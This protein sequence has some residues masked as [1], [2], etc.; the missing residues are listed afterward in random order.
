MME[1]I[2]LEKDLLIQYKTDLES[3]PLWESIKNLE[4]SDKSSELYYMKLTFLNIEK[5]FKILEQGFPITTQIDD[6]RFDIENFRYND[7]CDK[8]ILDAPIMYLIELF[9]QFRFYNY[10]QE[11]HS[12]IKSNVNWIKK[13]R[14]FEI[15]NKIRNGTIYSEIAEELDCHVSTISKINSKVQSSINNLKGRFFEIKFKRY[16]NSLDLIGCK[17]VRDGRPGKPDIYIVNNVKKEMWV[18]SLKNLE[19]NKNSFTIT[20]DKLMPEYNVARNMSKKFKIN[21]Y[22]VLFDSLTE[23]MFVEELDYLNPS[24]VIV[25][26]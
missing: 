9:K 15:Y 1:N 18:L 12:F 17:I 7:E 19:L 5:C 22:L 24:N 2:V 16:L 21:L 26:R 3:L 6:I 20:K 14:D 25:Y 10:Q 8:L 11:L 4:K 23:R 13:N